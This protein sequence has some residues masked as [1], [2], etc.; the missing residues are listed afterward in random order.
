ME[1]WGAFSVVDHKDPIRLAIE[2]LLY[3]KI[4]VPTP[5]DDHGSELGPMG[6]EQMGAGSSRWYC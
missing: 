1:R 3:D 4:A 5:V 2:P 6:K